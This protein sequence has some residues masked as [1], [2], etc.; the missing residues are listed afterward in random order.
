MMRSHFLAVAWIIFMIII[1]YSGMSSLRIMK[2]DNL[3]KR[4]HIIPIVY[5]S[6]WK[7]PGQ[8]DHVIVFCLNKEN[9]KGQ[10][11]SPKNFLVESRY[12]TEDQLDGTR[13]HPVEDY[14]GKDV[15]SKF[16]KFVR[17]LES[18]E[19]IDEETKEYLWRF[20]FSMF[21]RPLWLK[22]SLQS[23]VKPALEQSKHKAINQ[24]VQ[25]RAEGRNRSGRRQAKSSNYRAEISTEIEKKALSVLKPL[26]DAIRTQLHPLAVMASLSVE[27]SYDIPFKVVRTKSI[28]FISS[29][30]PCFLEED[31]FLLSFDG[32]TAVNQAFICPLSPNLAF[33]GGA[34]L[35]TGYSDVISEWARRFNAR[36]RANAKEKLIANTDLVDESWFLADPD[37][38]PTMKEV[39]DA[40]ELPGLKTKSKGFG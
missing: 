38:P 12:F 13:S 8:I 31:P 14:L 6:K 26:E 40:L 34:G 17:G 27:K 29:D 20:V 25:K 18:R 5:Q 37:S 1:Y 39:I 9:L 28:P 4:H 36:V 22:E 21:T 15:E 7:D 30:T 2:K 23:L 32:K 16:N 3:K 11:I 33:V 24:L 19:S 10:G 35:T